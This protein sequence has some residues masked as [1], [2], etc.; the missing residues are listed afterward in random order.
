MQIHTTLTTDE[1]YSGYA[2]DSGSQRLSNELDRLLPASEEEIKNIMRLRPP[3][4]CSL[5]S[6]PTDLLNKT[7]G[8]HVPYPVTIVNNSFK[9]RLF[10]VTAIV[11]LLLK[12]DTLDKDLS[13]NYRLTRRLT[14]CIGEVKRCVAHV[15]IF[16]SK[17]QLKT[18]RGCSFTI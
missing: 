3:K 10:P 16:T 5:D 17:H 8:V 9:Q 7:V 14:D 15:E 12:S 2:I 13:K 11:K 1:N 6:C 18:H 4:T